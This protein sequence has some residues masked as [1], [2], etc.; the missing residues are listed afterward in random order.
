M[1]MTDP[2]PKQLAMARR[3]AAYERACGGWD[4][5]NVEHPRSWSN[6]EGDG[7]RKVAAAIRKGDHLND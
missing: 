7:Q 4:D 6:V 2:T 1:T 5:P 3:I